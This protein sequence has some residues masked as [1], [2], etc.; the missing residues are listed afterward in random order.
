MAHETVT[1]IEDDAAWD[2]L[3]STRVT[4]AGGEN[5]ASF[6]SGIGLPSNF[7]EMGTT[8]VLGKDIVTLGDFQ[9]I[10]KLGEG[11]MGAVYKARQNSFNRAVALKILFPHVANIPKLVARL[12]RE[13]QVMFELDHPNIVKSFAYDHTDGFHY[14]AMEYVSG[15][16]MQKW[17]S[18]LGRIPVG[19]AVRVV[20]DCA[21]ALEYAHTLK[22]VHRDIK[23]DNILVHKTGAVKLADLGMVKIEDEEMSLTQTGHAVGTPWYMPLEQARNAKEIDGRS[24]IYALGCTLHAFLTGRPPFVGRTIVDVI[25]AKEVGTFPPARQTNSDV[26]E[27]LDLIIAK[28]TA[29]L[30]KNRYQSCTELIRDL[31]SLGLASKTLSFLVN[32]PQR[33]PSEETE[34]LAK[35]MTT[36]AP[37]KSR[38]DVDF[39]ASAAPLQDLDTWYV[40]VKTP[41][42]EVQTRKFSTAQLVKMVNEGTVAVTARASHSPTGS[43]RALSTYKEFQGLALGKMT[44]A[45]ADKNTARTR[46]LLKRIEE[47]ERKR[48]AEENA[49]KGEVETPFRA[50]LNYWG[51]LFVKFVLPIAAGIGILFGIV[52]WLKYMI[53]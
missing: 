34:K 3:G 26:P 27:R 41:D 31:E 23:P 7:T 14:V 37:M 50:N 48:E 38:A 25:Q 46:G 19:D 53:G 1:P 32:K 49:R 29:K 22:L 30:P 18:Q 24:D 39:A 52:W 42:G 44:R 5:S 35:T 11:A 51:G 13:A 10:K 43:F 36:A 9:L 12:E 16:S 28:M 2:V 15:Q 20:L 8:K 33:L 4:D 40:Q 45:A 21:R 17:M 47:E 6:G